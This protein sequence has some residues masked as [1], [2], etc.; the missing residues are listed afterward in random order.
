MTYTAFLLVSRNK[1]Q[2]A[3]NGDSLVKGCNAV[4]GHQ[5]DALRVSLSAPMGCVVSLGKGTTITGETRLAMNTDKLTV[6]V[7][8]TLKEY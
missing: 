6:Y 8:I 5:G 3:G 2:P 1:A 4:T 7:I